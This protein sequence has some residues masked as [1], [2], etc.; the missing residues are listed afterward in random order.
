[1]TEKQFMEAVLD[2]ARTFGWMAYHTF[3]SR[4]STGGFPDLVMVKPPRVLFV[5]CKAAKGCVTADQ[6]EWLAALA[7]CEWPET[8]LWR[9]DDMSSILALLSEGNAKVAV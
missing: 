3:D 6:E 2:A 7:G 8:Y 5:E 1:M 9:P 4:R